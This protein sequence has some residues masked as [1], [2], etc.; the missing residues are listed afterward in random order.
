MKLELKHLSPYLPY[1]LTN[2]RAFHTP[3]KIDGI[4]G[5]KVYFGDTILFINQIKPLLRPLSDLEE[6]WKEVNSPYDYPDFGH[7]ERSILSGHANY[8]FIIELIS[9]HFDVFGLI[10]KGLAINLNTIKQ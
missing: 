6:N 3:Q 1:G 2:Q 9:E 8:E 10:D 4:V 5:N 7:M